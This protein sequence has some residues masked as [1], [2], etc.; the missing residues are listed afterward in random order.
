MIVKQWDMLFVYDK[1][2]HDLWQEGKWKRICVSVKQRNQMG[3]K[4]ES[5][6]NW[7]PVCIGY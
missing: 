5:A 1:T 4:N 3:N 7:P 6:Q 2:S